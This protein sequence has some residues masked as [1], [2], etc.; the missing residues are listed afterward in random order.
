MRSILI[1]LSRVVMVAYVLYRS[2]TTVAF[3]PFVA[4]FDSWIGILSILLILLATGAI[5]LTF[6]GRNGMAFS[7]AAIV[8]AIALGSWLFIVFK[9]PVWTRSYF[10]WSVMPEVCFSLAGLTSWLVQRTQTTNSAD[11]QG[12][13]GE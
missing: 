4:S 8:G 10:A 5:V 13:P 9:A 7:L 6:F 2:F 12:V 1:G 11:E 3:L